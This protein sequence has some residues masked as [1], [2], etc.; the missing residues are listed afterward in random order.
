MTRRILL[1]PHV[2][3]ILVLLLI[4]YLAMPQILFD[5]G[6]ADYRLPVGLVFILIAGT[7]AG[8]ISLARARLIAVALLALFLVRMGLIMERW[9]SYDHIYQDFSRAIAGLPEGG[10]MVTVAT[11]MPDYHHEFNMPQLMYLSAIAI[12]E[13]SFF[14]PSFATFA[15]PGKQPVMIKPQYHQLVDELDARLEA[16]TDTRRYA[17]TPPLE[18]LMAPPGDA[19]DAR[20][21]LQHFDYALLLYATDDVN[22]APSL[23]EPLYVGPRFQLYR[24]KQAEATAA[25]GRRPAPLLPAAP[26]RGAPA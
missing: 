14:D 10:S 1:H 11:R 3:W 24:V 22:P 16:I 15:H 6:A 18:M 26:R 21:L 2:R 4:A 8:A 19:E 17:R 5:T 23:L 20:P 25:A 9:A 7:T 12:I 13:K